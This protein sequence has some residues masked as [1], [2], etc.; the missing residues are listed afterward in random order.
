MCQRLWWRVSFASTVPLAAQAGLAS[1]ADAKRA[2]DLAVDLIA[3]QALAPSHPMSPKVANGK[4]TQ[5]R[6]FFVSR[7]S[8]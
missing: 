6:S 5:M 4:V 8:R 1:P 2:V 7:G 3:A